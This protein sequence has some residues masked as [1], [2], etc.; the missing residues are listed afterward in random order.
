MKNV[1]SRMFFVDKLIGMGTHNTLRSASCSC[2]GPSTLH[3]QNFITISCRD[4]NGIEANE[5]KG[6]K[7]H[8]NVVS[9]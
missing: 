9:G 2:F 5:C 7:H 6:R 8:S 3:G 1:E 4:G